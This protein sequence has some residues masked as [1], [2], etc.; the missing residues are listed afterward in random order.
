M[1]SADESDGGPNFESPL[2][3]ES[4]VG[5]RKRVSAETGVSVL[6][7]TGAKHA[8]STSSDSPKRLRGASDDDLLR[9]SDL[10]RGA[11]QVE[12]IPLALANTEHGDRGAGQVE[13]APLALADTEHEDREA[14]E[15]ECTSSEGDG[16]EETIQ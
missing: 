10:L 13:C 16:M 9:E 7:G 14:G 6:S 1:E 3:A 2:E 11:G 5:S 4:S 12:C 8:S 15:A